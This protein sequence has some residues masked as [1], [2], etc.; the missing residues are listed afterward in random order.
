MRRESLNEQTVLSAR[1]GRRTRP[2][3]V[4]P[5]SDGVRYAVQLRLR[6]GGLDDRD[7]PL[8][9]LLAVDYDEAGGGL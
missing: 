6:G 8:A 7:V 2:Q 5:L 4:E 3:I 9:S 1:Q